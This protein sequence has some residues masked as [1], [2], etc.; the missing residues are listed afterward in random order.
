[1]I[2][3][4]TLFVIM[5]FVLSIAFMVVYIAYDNISDAIQDNAIIDQD[6]AD[7]FTEGADGFA[8]TWD[9]VFITIFIAVVIGVLIISYVLATQPVFFFVFTFLVIILGALGGYIANAFDE[10]ILDPVFSGASANFPIM[11]FVMSNYLLFVVVVV[12]LMLIV[13]YAKPNQGGF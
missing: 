7:R 8:S 2:R 5:L 3:D 1:M 6:I 11:S 13:F 10:L 4:A 9:Y 12:M